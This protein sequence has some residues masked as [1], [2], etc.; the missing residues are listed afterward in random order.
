MSLSSRGRRSLVLPALALVL[1]AACGAATSPTAAPPTA[2]PTKSPA[3]AGTP[4]HVNMPASV[5]GTW[6]A[7]LKGTG[8]TP[9]LWTLKIIKNEIFAI[10]PH[11]GA[12]AFPIGVTANTADHLNFYADQ[13]CQAGDLKEGTYTYAVVA[14]QLVFTLIQDNCRDRRELL[15]T[16]PWERQP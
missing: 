15:T 12:E 16:A 7:T 4:Y 2:A 3:P 5:I 10:N 11:E 13:E 14:D 1:V 9:G 8:V 6:H